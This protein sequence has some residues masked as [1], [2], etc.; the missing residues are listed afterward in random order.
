[1]VNTRNPAGTQDEISPPLRAPPPVSAPE[2]NSPP[3]SCRASPSL[4]TAESVPALQSRSR[5][6]SRRRSGS[7]DDAWLAPDHPC[8]QQTHEIAENAKHGTVGWKNAPRFQCPIELSRSPKT[9]PLSV[10][11]SLQYPPCLSWPG[12]STCIARAQVR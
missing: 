12:P 2:C 9:A 6:G 8:R 4:S 7:D 11:T 3:P 5:P 1:M 10:A